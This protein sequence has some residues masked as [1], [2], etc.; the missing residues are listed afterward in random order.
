MKEKVNFQNKKQV[1]RWRRRV[2]SLGTQLN[3][4][5]SNAVKIIR[6]E[7]PSTHG[8][9]G[10]LCLWCSNSKEQPIFTF[11]SSQFWLACPSVRKIQNLWF[12]PFRSCS[13]WLCSKRHTK[14]MAERS[15]T[16]SSMVK[17]QRSKTP[18]RR[19]LRTKSGQTSKSVT[20]SE[21]RKTKKFQQ[22]YS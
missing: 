10:H 20:L 22:T 3:I 13:S 16:M 2:S 4:L 5:M 21:L 19:S 1:K 18:I 8:W 11:C 15:R 14:I 12:S 7:Q 17:L 6:C 9:L